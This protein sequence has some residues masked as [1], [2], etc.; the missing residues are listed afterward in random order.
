MN[1]HHRKDVHNVPRLAVPDV[2]TVR[3]R[4]QPDRAISLLSQCD[5]AEL[6]FFMQQVLRMGYCVSFSATS[7]G[8]AVSITVFDGATKFKG[9]VRAA[10]EFETRYRDLLS[11]VRGEE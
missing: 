11:A 3:L 6:S 2:L 10:H 4:E 8:G 9:Y 5:M 1:G 7:D